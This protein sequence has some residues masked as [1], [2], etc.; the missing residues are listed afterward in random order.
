[1]VFFDAFDLHPNHRIKAVLENARQSAIFLPVISPSYVERPWPQ[2]EL[3]AFVEATAEPGRI[4]AVELL[5]PIGEYPEPL[6]HLKRKAFWWMDEK[7]GTAPR[8]STPKYDSQLYTDN[9]DDVA[10]S[11]AK[12]LRDMRRAPEPTP[13][14]VKGD[15]TKTVLLA[16][17]TDNLRRPIRQVR[18]YLEQF[19]YTVLPKYG[20]PD[21]A[22][23][24][25]REFES[26][27]ANAGLF[28][29]LLSEVRSTADIRGSGETEPI[30][31]GRYQYEAARRRGIGTLQWRE[32]DVELSSANHY[33]RPL[34]LGPHVVAMGL[35]EFMRRIK[36][37]LDRPAPRPLKKEKKGDFIF[38]NADRSDEE[39]ADQ[40]L[41][42][43]KAKSALM[44]MM[45]LF[46]GAADQILQDLEDNFKD[47]GALLL[48][49]GNSRPPWVRAQIRRYIK[50]AKTRD[51]PPQ[52]KSIILGPPAPKSDHD[53]GSAG[54]FTTI[55]C[56]NGLTDGHL[57]QL[58]AELHG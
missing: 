37:E 29:Q 19:G 36:S 9:L 50:L 52:V 5:P 23:D 2:D 43:I 26:N 42:L 48:V 7:R 56:Q 10:Y 33:D 55:D 27:L 47:C 49:Y 8:R 44:A 24:F 14:A 18:E 54:G 6:R 16:E 39:I 40:L 3:Q 1:M 57:Q 53:L 28:V 46:E 22:S 34:L 11:I 41:N 15:T 51:E 25:V 45:P 4:F 20:Y 38:I 35:Q 17:V 58:I 31:R 21:A 30:S 13:P 32:S 12:R